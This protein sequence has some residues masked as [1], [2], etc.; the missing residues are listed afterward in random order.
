MD[1]K[2]I[3]IDS[4]SDHSEG[5]WQDCTEEQLFG[6]GWTPESTQTLAW[7]NLIFNKSS[8]FPFS[9]YSPYSLSSGK[10]SRA[11]TLSINEDGV[12]C[13]FSLYRSFWHL[14]R[15]VVTDIEDNTFPPKRTSPSHCVVI[16]IFLIIHSN[17]SSQEL[18]TIS[19]FMNIE[20]RTGTWLF[21]LKLCITYPTKDTMIYLI[22]EKECLLWGFYTLRK[23]DIQRKRK[24]NISIPV[25]ENGGRFSAF[26]TWSCRNIWQL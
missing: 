16:L 15:D 13:I 9:L 22:Q 23:H 6:T 12:R 26:S 21:L 8:S 18:T 7:N 25:W 20:L 5:E 4:L 3:R 2:S 17:L 14:I 11:E 24:R 1:R 10:S 19:Q